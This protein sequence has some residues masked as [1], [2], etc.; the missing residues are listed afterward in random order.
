MFLI[1][2]AGW[3]ALFLC[4][5]AL[6]SHAWHSRQALALDAHEALRARDYFELHLLQA[7]V[8]LLSMVV[9]WSGAGLWFGAPGMVYGLL[10]PL[11]WW[12]GNLAER[13]HAAL[14]AAG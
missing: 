5:A 12:H 4:F 6:Y 2:G 11:G 9:A 3:S 7:G 14:E 8:G 13:R 1:Y 10:G